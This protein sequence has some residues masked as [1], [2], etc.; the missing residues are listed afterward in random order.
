MVPNVIMF[1]LNTLFKHKDPL[2]VRMVS[3]VVIMTLLFIG[4]TALVKVDSSK[5]T[6]DFFYITI[7]T[8]I[9]VN[10]ATAIYQ[11]GLFGLSGMMPPKYTGAV[12]TGQGIGG[13]FAALA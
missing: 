2:K 3:S 8:V 5:W 6:N 4:T 12:M 10:M 1:F 7:G 13:T 11:G 9:L